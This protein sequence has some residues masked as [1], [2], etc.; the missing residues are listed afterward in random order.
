MWLRTLVSTKLVEGANLTKE[1]WLICSSQHIFVLQLYVHW[2][3]E[4]TGRRCKS[5]KGAWLIC[6][7]T[8]IYVSHVAQIPQKVQI[9]HRSVADL[10]VSTYL[11]SQLYVHWSCAWLCT[12]WV[13]LCDCVCKVCTCV[14]VNGWSA[15]SIVSQR[16][17]YCI[18]VQKHIFIYEVG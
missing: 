15:T 13:H 7:S 9:L 4:E 10:F 18:L 16:S 6:L 3:C 17:N 11:A 5:Y 8:H 14:K 12:P 1:E 2:S